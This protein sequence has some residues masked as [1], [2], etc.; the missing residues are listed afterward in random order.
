[1]KNNRNAWDGFITIK[2]GGANEMIK[3]HVENNTS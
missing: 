1:M 2:N 3:K